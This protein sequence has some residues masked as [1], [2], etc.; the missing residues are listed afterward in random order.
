MKK[1]IKKIQKQIIQEEVLGL[2]IGLK[3]ISQFMVIFYM[4]T[5]EHR[6]F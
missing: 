1:E 4:Y 2:A 6:E 3:E 5:V